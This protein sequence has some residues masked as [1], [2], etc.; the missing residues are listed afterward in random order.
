MR[1]SNHFLLEITHRIGKAEAARRLGWGAGTNDRY[2]RLMVDAKGLENI[3]RRRY[4]IWLE[5]C[6]LMM[7]FG[8]ETQLKAARLNE[9]EHRVVLLID[10]ITTSRQ[11]TTK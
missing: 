4:L 7:R 2:A 1:A 5:K 11:V 3:L 9:E 10:E 6:V 8:V